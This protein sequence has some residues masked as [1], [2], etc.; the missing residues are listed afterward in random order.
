[1]TSTAFDD[2]DDDVMLS[3]VSVLAGCFALGSANS[4]PP[5][6]AAS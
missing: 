4:A 5:P 1:M 6:L 3:S 2:E